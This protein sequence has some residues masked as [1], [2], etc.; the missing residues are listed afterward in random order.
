MLRLQHSME[1][2]RPKASKKYS[3]RDVIASYT[4]ANPHA[5]RVAKHWGAAVGSRGPC[6]D[7]DGSDVEYSIHSFVGYG[8]LKSLR[9]MYS[10]SQAREACSTLVAVLEFAQSL[11]EAAPLGPFDGALA[12]AR[13]GLDETPDC[14]LICDLFAERNSV[15]PPGGSIFDALAAFEAMTTAKKG[16]MERITQRFKVLERVSRASIS[17]AGDPAGGARYPSRC[18]ADLKLRQWGEEDT[19]VVTLTGLD[20]SITDLVRPNMIL[21]CELERKKG[22]PADAPW[23]AIDVFGCWPSWYAPD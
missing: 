3:W 10:A 15:C 5:P 11:P 13:A 2:R 16:A 18:T 21:C 17:P 23:T 8:L 7:D 6:C 1:K 12:A 19:A 4:A 22:G 14:L 9:G 20:A